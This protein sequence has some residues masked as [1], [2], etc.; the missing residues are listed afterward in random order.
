MTALR[1][2][3]TFN[4]DADRLGGVLNALFLRGVSI[5]KSPKLRDREMISFDRFLQDVPDEVAAQIHLYLCRQAALALGAAS[6]SLDME[7]SSVFVTAARD[8][9]DCF[10]EF[11]EL[12]ESIF[13]GE[14]GPQF[15]FYSDEDLV[16]L[17]GTGSMSG[18]ESAE[19]SAEKLKP[20]NSGSN[21]NADLLTENT[22]FFGGIRRWVHSAFLFLMPKGSGQ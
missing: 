21:V 11:V 15:G 2:S 4:G 10:H 12:P 8:S 18:S 1:Y 22:R 5:D 7:K 9:F 16:D 17:S 13:V 3:M 20:V 6:L 14:S 19:N